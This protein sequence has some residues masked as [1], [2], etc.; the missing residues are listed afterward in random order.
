[1]TPNLAF[2][3]WTNQ[4][5]LLLSPLVYSL[6][7]SSCMSP[8][9]YALFDEIPLLVASLPFTSTTSRSFFTQDFNICVF[10]GF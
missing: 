1:M 8:L 3:S 5:E 9:V 4:D 2:L 7:D 6:F 10:N